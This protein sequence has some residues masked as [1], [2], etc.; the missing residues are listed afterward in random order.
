MSAIEDD[1]PCVQVRTLLRPST[2]R[3]FMAKSSATGLDVGLLLSLVADGAV[4]N[5]RAD[6]RPPE[7]RIRELNAAGLSDS[8][9]AQRMDM[10][11]STVSNIRERLGLAAAGKGGRKKK[12]VEA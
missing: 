10:P 8:K 9:I 3:A 11:R 5:R 7:S 6:V 2:Y 4:A 1:E 12:E